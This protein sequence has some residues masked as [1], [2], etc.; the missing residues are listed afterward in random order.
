MTPT[1]DRVVHDDIEASG[2]ASML[3]PCF[4]G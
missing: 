1:A 2:T 3:P 4:G